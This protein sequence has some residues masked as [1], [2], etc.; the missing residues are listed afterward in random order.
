MAIFPQGFSSTKARA[1]RARDGGAE[2]RVLEQLHRCLEDDYLVWHNVPIGRKQRQPDIVIL[3]PSRGLLVLEVKAWKPAAM[4]EVTRNSVTLRVESGATKVHSHPLKQARGYVQELVTLMEADPALRQVDGRH[5][6]KFI[7]PWGYGCVMAQVDRLKITDPNWDTLFAPHLTLTREDLLPDL[8]PAVFQERLWGMFSVQFRHTM[9][10]PQRDRIRWHLFPELRMTAQSGLFDE[11]VAPDLPPAESLLQVMDL[12]QERLARSLGAGHR[13]VHGVAGSGKS[14]ILIH[15]AQQL[16]QAARADRPVL[17]LCYNKALSVRLDAILRQRGVDER[18]Q[19]RTFHSWCYDMAR[20]YQVDIPRKANGD[21]DLDGLAMEVVQAVE[22]GRIPK[23]QYA[24]LLIDEAHDFEDTWLSLTPQLI[25][26]ESQSLLVL[27]DDAQSIYR[28][29][30]RNFSFA[31][32][33]IRAQGRTSVLRINYRNTSEVLGLATG[34]VGT[35][36]SGESPDDKQDDIAHVKPEDGGR[37]G[38]PPELI[39][40]TSGKAEARQVALRVKA[41]LEQGVAA[42]SIGVIARRNDMLVGVEDELYRLKIKTQH[43]KGARDWQAGSVKLVSMHACKGLE[44]HTAM[45]I[46]L[47]A[48]PDSR[49]HSDEEWRLLYVAMT[50][51][52]HELVLSACGQSA[53]V[54]K[55]ARALDQVRHPPMPVATAA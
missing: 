32:V 25:D 45:V 43:L 31:S 50:R 8:P 49:S 38:T 39:R 16:A 17:V 21:T 12:Q 22:R 34:T 14:M 5:A 1:Q 48:L 42:E 46:G 47:E 33:G 54:H 41:V 29:P 40:C 2:A 20:T 3:H 24:A 44:F 53:A 18:V 6:G 26:P 52:T 10:L 28:K 36:L 35:L 4:T 19:V 9:S 55:V 30:R 23:G 27:Y 11:Q 7:A 51:A 37:H 15:R 13:V